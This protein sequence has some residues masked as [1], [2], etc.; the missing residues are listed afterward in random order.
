[1]HW[2]ENKLSGQVTDS[3]DDD[4][5]NARVRRNRPRDNINDRELNYYPIGLLISKGVS[6]LSLTIISNCG[7]IGADNRRQSGSP[8]HLYSMHCSTCHV[9]V[10]DG[11]SVSGLE[12]WSW[13]QT[14]LCNIIIYFRPRQT[15]WNQSTFVFVFLF[16]Y[17]LVWLVG[18]HSVDH[19]S[20]QLNNKLSKP[21]V[22]WLTEGRVCCSSHSI[23]IR[24]TMAS[25]SSFWS[26]LL[27]TRL[28]FVVCSYSVLCSS[29]PPSPFIQL[30]KDN[31]ARNNLLYCPFHIKKCSKL[32][33]R[34]FVAKILK[35]FYSCQ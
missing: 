3:L 14:D 33:A 7:K 26:P 34:V 11:G 4:G 15:S 24:R 16:F 2:P 9:V 27:L 5:Q 23:G 29:C 25:S 10:V 18:T 8:T 21:G 12:I 31:K 20:N 28:C 32:F 19:P 6:S 17:W 35:P 30:Q 13:D 22:E 1:M